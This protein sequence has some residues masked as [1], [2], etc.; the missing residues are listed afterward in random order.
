LRSRARYPRGYR[1]GWTNIDVTEGPGKGA[2]HEDLRALVTD[3]DDG[4]VLVV[5]DDIA[6][7][8]EI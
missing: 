1:P 7:V 5:G 2:P 3:L 6:R 4:T 8:E